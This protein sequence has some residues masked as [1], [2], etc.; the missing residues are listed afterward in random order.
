VVSR[1]SKRAG[2]PLDP[3][4]RSFVE[5][6][7][8]VTN[9]GAGSYVAEDSTRAAAPNWGY[10]CRSSTIACLVGDRAPSSCSR[11]RQRYTRSTIVT[12]TCRSTN[13]P[14][15]SVRR[16]DRALLAADT[17]RAHPEMNATAIASNKQATP[18][19]DVKP[20]RRSACHGAPTGS[21]VLAMLAL[22]AWLA[23]PPLRCRRG[24]AMPG[25]TES[26]LFDRTES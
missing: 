13:G 23:P 21:P 24:R 3:T 20:G 7:L 19:A 11:S 26:R 16:A 8:E 15:C 10:K 12:P 6:Q 2:Q 17:P 18:S 4:R 1:S 14:A 22:L 5:R 25:R 9:G